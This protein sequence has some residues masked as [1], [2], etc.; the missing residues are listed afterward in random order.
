MRIFLVTRR[1]WWPGS[2]S[3]LLQFYV[4]YSAVSDSRCSIA[5]PWE[6]FLGELDSALWMILS[7]LKASGPLGKSSSAIE[8]WRFR[9]REE[10]GW[11]WC[12]TVSSCALTRVAAILA[13]IGETESGLMI[14]EHERFSGEDTG[15]AWSNEDFRV[16]VPE[17]GFTE[18][19]IKMQISVV[20]GVHH[21]GYQ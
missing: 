15:A 1:K 4:V 12:F 6:N 18:V 3:V 8:S 21:E 20:N 5:E 17:T 16:F 10:I 9:N 7:V 14:S 11:V 19:T 13:V 2:R